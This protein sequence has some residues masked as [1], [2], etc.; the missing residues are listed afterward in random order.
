MKTAAETPP[1]NSQHVN[2]RFL[3]RLSHARKL[4]WAA[5]LSKAPPVGFRKLSPRKGVRLQ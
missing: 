1:S 2:I 4:D 3:D 5:T